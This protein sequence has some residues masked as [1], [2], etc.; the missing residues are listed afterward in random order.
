VVGQLNL[1]YRR[2]GRWRQDP[3]VIGIRGRLTVLLDSFNPER[4][5]G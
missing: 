4:A 3:A 2:L 1:L 5:A